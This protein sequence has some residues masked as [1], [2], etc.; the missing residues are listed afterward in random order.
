MSLK[1]FCACLRASV[2]LSLC[3][4]SFVQVAIT[5]VRYRKIFVQSCCTII[6]RRCTIVQV[7]ITFV[8]L[9][10]TFV[11]DCCT[12]VQKCCTIVQVAITFGK[13][14]KTFVQACCTIV[15]RHCTIETV[16]TCSDISERHNNDERTEHLQ[17]RTIK[18][19]LA[20]TPTAYN[21]L[22]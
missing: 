4:F 1:D 3:S 9:R 16:T 8:R 20:F 18:K 14:R 22:S 7:A 11:Q 6:Q 12:N 5:F 2:P 19:P 15:Q 17:R 13:L 10:K 21:I